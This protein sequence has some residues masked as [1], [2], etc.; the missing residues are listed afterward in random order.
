MLYLL[1]FP[2]LVIVGVL[3]FLAAQSGQ[4][5]V[6]RSMV[7]RCTPEQAFERVRDLRSWRDWS[8][9]LL[10]EPDAEV[11]YSDD[12]TA[13]GGWYA[14]SGR[15][16]GAGRITHVALH[17]PERIEQRIAFKRPFK[18]NAAVSWEFAATEQDGS[19]AT[20]AFWSMRGRMPFLLRFMA[21]AMSGLIGQ[22]YELGL[23]LLRA[24]LD[25]AA[26]QLRIRFPGEVDMPAQH[27]WTIP[28]E[29]GLSDIKQAM[30][31]GFRRLVGVAAE[32]GVTP[33][34]PPFSAYRLADP[35]AGRLGFEVALPVPEGADPGELAH[36]HFAGGPH[37]VTEVQGSY[38]FMELGWHAAMGH[39]RMLKRQWDRGRPALEV[40]E[41]GPN[42][43]TGDDEL[44]TRI[45]IP[46]KP[47]R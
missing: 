15:L 43:A 4:I 22:D 45:L 41:Q 29:G 5:A 40:Y 28:F 6:R 36:Q 3:L 23:T 2:L 37:L 17:P 33:T 9:W 11:S 24:R 7:I 19:P 39:L 32:R 21:P 13:R 1:L 10:H 18:S 31:D 8:P 27:A 14:W 26:A 38:E 16:T 20:E 42:E 12:P 25:P 30:A 34:G 47:L 35:K 44:L 46:L